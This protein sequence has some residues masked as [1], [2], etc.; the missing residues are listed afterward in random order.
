MRLS[1]APPRRCDRL[2]LALH[3][4][5]SSTPLCTCHRLSHHYRLSGGQAAGASPQSGTQLIG[6]DPPLP[7]PAR[8]VRS[9]CPVIGR[10]GGRLTGADDLPGN[11]LVCSP[12]IIRPRPYQQDSEGN[13]EGQTAV[14][15]CHGKRNQDL[16]RL[17]SMLEQELENCSGCKVSHLEWHRPDQCLLRFWLG[18]Q[19]NILS[20]ECT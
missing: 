5:L 14:S 4:G 10:G 20:P 1:A 9:M 16:G 18:M 8:R 15:Q 7:V 13:A 11:S 17:L 2:C 3:T 19:S 12:V 6:I